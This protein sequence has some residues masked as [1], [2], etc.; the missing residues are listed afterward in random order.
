LK[1][2][3]LFFSIVLFFLVIAGCITT[4]PVVPQNPRISPTPGS[5]AINESNATGYAALL[6]TT[7]TVPATTTVPSP[8]QN[9]DL[10]SQGSVNKMYYYTLNGNQGFIPIKVYTGVNNYITSLGPIYSGDDYNAVIS[11]EIQREYVMPMVNEINSSGK[12]PDDAARIA[13]NLVQHIKYDANALNEIQVNKSKSDQLYIG[14][15]PY[16]ILFQEWGGICGEKSFLLA[17]MLKE[18]GY[19]VALIEFDF[20]SNQ[21]GHMAVGIKAPSPYTFE[22]TGYALIESTAPTIPTFD[23]YYLAGMNAPISS[24][25]PAK[26]IQVSD[27]MSF[28]SIG[29]EFSD[30]QTEQTVYSAWG[31]VNEAATEMNAAALQLNNLEAAVLSWRSKVETDYSSGGMSSYQYDLQMYNQAYNDYQ[32]YYTTV[33]YPAY[34]TWHNLDDNFQNVYMP[35]ETALENKYGM[36]R[37]INVGIAR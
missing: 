2:R 4:N 5:S 21:S 3:Y 13:I 19:N 24:F 32:N 15:Y 16:T 23:G 33:Y 20:G 35:K 30:A 17:L 11:N 14:R 18:L 10:E 28:A 25:T 37:G 31:Q 7:T 36:N 34:T 8:T 6:P 12:N 26:V 9:P 29:A 1:I 22:N 27:G